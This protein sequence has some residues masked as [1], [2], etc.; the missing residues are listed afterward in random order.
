[1]HKFPPANTETPLEPWSLNPGETKS[2]S[3]V[4][5]CMPDVSVVAV[6]AFEDRL[7]CVGHPC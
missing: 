5:C 1:M 3:D 7:L 2:L 6:R 4:S